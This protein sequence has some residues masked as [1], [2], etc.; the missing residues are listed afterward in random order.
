VKRRLLQ[1]C[2]TLGLLVT[3]LATAAWVR[4]FWNYDDFA[5]D[6]SVDDTRHFYEGVMLTVSRF[7]I[8]V[9]W[10]RD[11]RSPG[12]PN[13]GEKAH[14]W[15]LTHDGMRAPTEPP[16]EG[17]GF[18]F[19][20]GKNPSRL[21][22]APRYYAY[23]R[24]PTWFVPVACT[25]LTMLPIVVLSRARRRRRVRRQ[26]NLCSAC[27]YDLRGADHERCPECGEPVT[28]IAQV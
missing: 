5:I 10:I 13:L 1:F 8:Y 22:E 14:G 6:R 17:L 27:A 4:A 11:Y 19:G 3:T 2:F 26:Q 16:D 7:R 12:G 9:G 24:S 18:A 15:R 28:P 25:A 20:C 23:V 21:A